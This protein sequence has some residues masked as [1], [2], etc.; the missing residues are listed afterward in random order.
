MSVRRG[1]VDSQPDGQPGFLQDEVSRNWGAALGYSKDA[2]VELAVLAVK[3]RFITE[4]PADTLPYHGSERLLDRYLGDT[5]STFRVRLKLAHESWEIG[6]CPS[7]L[8]SELALAGIRGAAICDNGQWADFTPG[9]NPLTG[10]QYALGEEYWRFWITID[11]RAFHDFVAAAP[12]G[13]GNW[14]A[15]T[16]G[17]STMPANWAILPTIIKKHKPADS[18]CAGIQV[19]LSGSVWES[20]RHWGDG[21]TWGGSVVAVPMGYY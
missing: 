19:I 7:G 20:A 14:G 2:L 9:H 11:D 18:I 1:Y 6:D 10:V 12:W 13:T 15:K 16:W 3:C 17:F 21:S 4:C 5:D 8:L